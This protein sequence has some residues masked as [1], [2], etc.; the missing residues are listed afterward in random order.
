[1]LREEYPTKPE[2]KAT[3]LWKVLAIR[4]TPELV[5]A[6]VSIGAPIFWKHITTPRHRRAKNNIE[7]LVGDASLIMNMLNADAIGQA[8]REA[9]IATDDINI[10]FKKLLNDHYAE[11]NDIARKLA[12]IDLFNIDELMALPVLEDYQYTARDVAALRLP[13]HR[14]DDIKAVIERG[15]ASLVKRRT[16]I[17]HA[18]DR[19][20]QN[21]EEG[22]CPVCCGDIVDDDAIIMRCCS[23]L[24]CASC[25]VTAAGLRATTEN[26]VG[27][28]P[29]CQSAISFNSLIFLSK[30]VDLKDMLVDGNFAPQET[31]DEKIEGTKFET[32]VSI[33]MDRPDNRVPLQAEKMNGVLY[34]TKILPLAPYKKVIIYAS[35][36]ESLERLHEQLTTAG[37]KNK[38]LRGSCKEISYAA[39]DFESDSDMNVLLINGA[40]Y[41]AGLNLQSASDLIFANKVEHEAQ[42][43]GRVQRLGQKYRVNI[44]YL[45]DRRL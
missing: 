11:F 34:G 39:L 13:T 17:S 23:K 40:R 16:E 45:E 32:I 19:V 20:K 2:F 6:S 28:C 8:A 41:A 35:F 18:L 7:A 31:V 29:N 26:I 43:I 37:M 42:M 21:M 4:N 22:E 15:I 9:G 10:L 36:D 25:G 12:A 5:E 3:A 1:M 27:K 14:V 33:I 30:D 44:H 38:V 24:L